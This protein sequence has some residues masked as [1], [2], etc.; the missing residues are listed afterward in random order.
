MVTGPEP[1]DELV[2]LLARVHDED[3]APA[4]DSKAAKALFKEVISMDTRETA[5]T[6]AVPEPIS[7]G[8]WSRRGP[9]RTVA[10]A[11]AAVL[12]LGAGGSYAASQMLSPSEQKSAIDNVS[13]NI[14]LPPGGNF[15]AV[16]SS[17]D[18]QGAQQDQ[19]GLAG[20][21]AFAAA[22]QWYGYWLDGYNHGD[23]SQM[24]TAQET[25]DAIPTW[26]QLSAMGSGAGSTVS[27]M[28]QLAGSVDA[29][30][31]VPVRQFVAVNCSA[32]PWGTSASG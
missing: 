32:E 27:S 4:S 22:C 20:A 10:L 26:S 8:R 31:A 9:V 6:G 5:H 11:A 2:G 17:I 30:N 24:S 21:L 1:L 3:L 13:E 12:V 14:P 25:I 18:Q 19:T 23:Q 28:K 29:R 7:R 16:R 15:D